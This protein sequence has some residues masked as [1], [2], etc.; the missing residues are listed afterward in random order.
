MLYGNCLFEYPSGQEGIVSWAEHQTNKCKQSDT[1]GR[2]THAGGIPS[3]MYSQ[4]LT[5]A[6]WTG[7][8]PPFTLRIQNVVSDSLLV[9]GEAGDRAV[10][11]AG[12]SSQDFPAR[13]ESISHFNP[14]T[15]AIT[16]VINKLL[17][18]IL[19]EINSRAGLM[20]YYWHPQQGETVECWPNVLSSHKIGWHDDK[21]R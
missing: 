19:F 20:Q 21:K 8:S 2:Q 1:D 9:N 4:R 16:V 13:G 3:R 12:S 14:E 17:L 10:G 15:L 5:A 18:H 11:G 6:V 7:A